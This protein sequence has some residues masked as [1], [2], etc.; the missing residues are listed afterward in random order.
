MTETPAV[1]AQIFDMQLFEMVRLIHTITDVHKIE[2]ARSLKD[3]AVTDML[4]LF[5]LLAFCR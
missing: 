1:C 5:M 4:K 3:V 2:G